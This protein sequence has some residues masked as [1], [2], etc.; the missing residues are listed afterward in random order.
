MEVPTVVNIRVANL[1]N[2]GYDNL[3]KWLENPLHLYIGREMHFYVKGAHK[4]K[5][6]NPYSTKKYSLDEVL[7]LYREHI[8]N[9]DL[10]DQ[11]DELSGK[12]LGCW[13]SPNPCHGNVLIELFKQKFN[14]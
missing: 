6:H 11:L 1:R 5:W 2:L 10:Y 7:R 3:E 12:V 8:I 14:I 9:S 13:C 4:S